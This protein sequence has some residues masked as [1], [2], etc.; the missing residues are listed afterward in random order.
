VNN[1]WC[2]GC[3]DCI[4]V[5]DPHALSYRSSVDEAKS[6]FESGNTIAAILSPSIS[7]ESDDI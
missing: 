1:D 4:L 7:A 3:G 5:C 2:I 6:L